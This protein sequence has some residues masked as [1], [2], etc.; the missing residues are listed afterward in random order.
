M[1]YNYKIQGTE[2]IFTPEEHDKIQGQLRTGKDAFLVFR[3]GKIGV[4]TQNVAA[5]KETGEQTDEQV[6]A[7]YQTL[8]APKEDID[9]QREP[10]RKLFIQTREEFYKKM[11]WPI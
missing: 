1:N 9:A 2:Y 8:N 6:Q 7:K 11:G 10:L 4:N 3:G 5:F